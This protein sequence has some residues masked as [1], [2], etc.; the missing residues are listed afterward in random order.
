MFPACAALAFDPFSV[1]DWPEA[2]AVTQAYGFLSAFAGDTA[3]PLHE[4]LAPAKW[5]PDYAPWPGSNIAL[6]TARAASGVRVEGWRVGVVAREEWFARANRPALDLFEQSQSGLTL[7]GVAQQVRYELH[8]WAA[9]GLELGR[10]ATRELAPGWN[11]KAGASLALLDGLRFRAEQWQ[12][13]FVPL[14]PGVVLA[15]GS[16][17]RDND[18]LHGNLF[19]GPIPAH[20]QGSGEG[21]TLDLML[22][23]QA[24]AGVRLDWVAT[25]AMG[26]MHWRGIPREQFTAKDYV[27]CQQL[28]VTCSSAKLAYADMASGAVV[29]GSLAEHPAAKQR[30]AVTVPLGR[31]QLRLH[32]SR[33]Y[34]E[35][36][37]SVGLRYPLGEDRPAGDQPSAAG[38]DL[39]LSYDTRFHSWCLGL[40]G[41]GLA[42][43]LQSDQLTLARAR[44]LA[45]QLGLR[46][47]LR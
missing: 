2:P 21:Y 11:A 13:N 46:F 43:A 28:D 34:G 3:V 42:L 40:Q 35:N 18:H 22:G 30:F 41:H 8:G 44:V 23:L 5:K 27:V 9:S 20:G 6:A 29:N 14:S 33:G 39:S 32:D 1:P 25:D 24:P 15:N 36:F 26:L 16:V 38:S 12:G 17:G 31:A 4:V 37:P 47:D 10:T 45:L 7:P 19:G